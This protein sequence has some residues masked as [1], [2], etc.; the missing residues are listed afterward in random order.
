L[1]DVNLK[2]LIFISAVGGGTISWWHMIL[3]LWSCKHNHMPSEMN[4]LCSKS[5]INKAADC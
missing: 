1:L 4:T 3:C 5:M 2:L